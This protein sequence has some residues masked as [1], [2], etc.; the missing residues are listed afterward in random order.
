MA[1]G[2]VGSL[3]RWPVKS[4]GGEDLPALAIDGFGAAGD[5]T[6]AVFDVFRNR[7]RRVNAELLPRLLA[8]SAAYPGTGGDEL[9]RERTPQ[10]LVTAPDGTARTWDDPALADALGEDLGR[11][12][13]LGRETRGQQDRPATVHLTV[14]ATLRALEEALGAPVDVHR[15]RAN[16]HLEL[17]A[18]PWAEHEWIG[19][20]LQVGAAELEIIEGCERCA[21][22]T[23]DPRTQDKWPQL[24]RLLARERATLFGVIARATGPAIVREGDRATLL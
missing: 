13:S 6:H 19:R 14:G 9:V 5:R 8:W 22:P 3:H 17:D 4:M 15:F 23:R 12:V 16:I 10:P 20:R 18:A 21:I 1:A 11:A 2:H 24:L 7:P